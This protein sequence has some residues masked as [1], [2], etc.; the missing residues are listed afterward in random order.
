MSASPEALAALA[1]HRFGMGPR[2]GSLRAIASDPRG[3]ML[4]DLDKPGAGQ[5]SSVGLPTSAQAFRAVAEFTAERQARQKLDARK[6]KEDPAEA[7]MAP[8]ADTPGAAGQPLPQQL[9]NNEIKARVDA[10]AGAEIGFVERLAWF[11]SNHFCVSADKIQS[12]CGPYE[13]EAIRPRV[14]GRFVDLLLAVESHPAMLVYLDNAAS[15]GPN[16]VAGLNRD[17]GIDENLAREILELHTLGVRG[18]YTQ[19][20]VTRFAFALTGWTFA[21]ALGESDHGGEFAYVP[22]MHEPGAQTILGRG[23]ADTG[24]GQARAVLTD[25]AR[26]PATATHVATKLATHFVA[27]QPP[28]ALVEKLTRTFVETE[29]D[30]RL[31]A[32]A[33]VEAPESWSEER[34]KLKRPSEWIVSALRVTGARPTVQR[35]AGG[36]AR[37]GEPIWR[38]PSPRGFADDAASWADGLGDRLDIAAAYGEANAARLDPRALVDVALGPL[39]STATRDAV[40]RA[41]SKPQALTLLLM[42]PEFLRR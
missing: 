25:L 30:L 33:L 5:V 38:P 9:L 12:M 16:S 32:R 24:A 41:E 11:W 37:L 22:R 7:M 40:A 19:Q 1:L 21:P 26:H 29:G 42:S 2:P 31:V 20:D 13:R 10:A 6:K 8:A 36:H 23:Y 17:R 34:V 18:G 4:A 28:P 15:I 3:A 39:A 35:L 14:L 27:D